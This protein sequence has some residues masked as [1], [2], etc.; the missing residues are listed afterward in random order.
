MIATS[1]RRLA[2][3]DYISDKRETTIAELMREFG[4]SKS[5]IRRDLDAI[6]ETTSFEMVPGNGGGIRATDGW[7]SSHRYL[8]DKQERLLKDLMAGL[9]PE[10]KETM[11]SILAAFGKPQA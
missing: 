3:R 9:Q 2:I 11:E 4:V 5:T 7:Y 1:D 8:S 10:Q 6:T